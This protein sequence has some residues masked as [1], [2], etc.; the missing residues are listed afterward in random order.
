MSG[1]HRQDIDTTHDAVIDRRVWARYSSEQ[2]TFFQPSSLQSPVLWRARIRDVS[3]RGIG[4]VLS[5]AFEIGTRLIVEFPAQVNQPLKLLPV[6]V[7]HVTGTSDNQW[8]TGCEL[9][10]S[11][12]AAELDALR[13][14]S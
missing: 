4:L 3:E 12:T 9:G 14:P 5:R 6:R 11:L 10:N 13:D 8:I 1:S 7:V 2:H